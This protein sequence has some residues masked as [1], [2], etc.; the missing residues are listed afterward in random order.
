MRYGGL[1]VARSLGRAG[2]PV[3]AIGTMPGAGLRS[4]YWT[5]TFIWD[6]VGRSPRDTVTFLHEVAKTIGRRAILIPT[7]DIGATVV[8]GAGAELEES[9]DFPKVDPD[10]L[11]MMINKQE[12]SALATRLGVP[13]AQVSV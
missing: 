4:R 10:R 12:M 13:T 9:F 8:A 3:Y 6:L 1:G 11:R 7:T 5:R 2:V